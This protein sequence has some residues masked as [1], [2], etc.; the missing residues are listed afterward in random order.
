LGHFGGMWFAWVTSI[1]M[2]VTAAVLRRR[3]VTAAFGFAVVLLL[4]SVA[5]GGGSGSSGTSGGGSSNVT[6]GTPAGTYQI[7]VTGTSATVSSSMPVTL[8]VN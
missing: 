6:P 7:T 8:Q 4:V 5:C 3:P 1:L 2:V